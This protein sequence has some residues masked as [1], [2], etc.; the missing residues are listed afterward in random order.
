ELEVP[1]DAR[2]GCVPQQP[3]RSRVFSRVSASGDENLQGGSCR[4][5][6]RLLLRARQLVRQLLCE[7]VSGA[8]C[9]D[10][11]A[12]GAPPAC[13]RRPGESLEVG[14]VDQGGWSDRVTAQPDLQSRRGLAERSGLLPAVE[15]SRAAWRDVQYFPGASSGETG[16]RHGGAGYRGDR[17]Y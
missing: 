11:P 4:D 5:F 15:K 16:G 14:A 13:S 9:R 12:G 1:D 10:W 2:N 8:I 17:G 7:E 6:A 3:A